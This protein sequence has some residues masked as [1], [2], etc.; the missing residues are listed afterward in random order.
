MSVPPGCALGLDHVGVVGGDLGALAAAYERLGFTLT[1]LARHAGRRV[2]GGPVVSFGTGNRCVMLRQGYLELLAVLDPAAASATVPG[3]LARYAGVHTLALEVAEAA[4]ALPRLA[5]AGFAGLGVTAL[6]RPANGDEPEGPR[7]RF[8]LVAVAG[9]PEGRMNLIAHHT[10]DLVWQPRYLDHANHAVALEELVIASAAPAATAAGLARL[11]GRPLAPD[12]L[13]GYALAV[14]QG[15]VRVLDPAGLER[16]LP[17][18]VPPCLP[19]MACVGVRSADGNAA[20]R[21][22]VAA[23]G[24]AAREDRAGLVIDPA[25]AG[26]VALRFLA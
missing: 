8:S 21:G 13:G 10:R 14:G 7:A 11:A 24:I 17:G 20:I 19:W 12:P 6:D 1:P 25:A 22:L 2:A 23:R 15:R 26:G 16:L 9:L 5:L 18:V 4:A 3:F